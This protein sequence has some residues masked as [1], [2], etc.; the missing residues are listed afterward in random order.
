MTQQPAPAA[1][2]PVVP[3]PG[4]RLA[5]T[6]RGT[7]PA[8]LL[9]HGITCSRAHDARY[10]LP[11]YAPVAAHH[12]LVAYDARGHGESG[13]R[14]EPAAY[15]WSALAG[16]ML[17]LAD[18]FS[19]ETPVAAI[20]CSMGTATALHAALRAPERF[21]ALVLTAVP[22]AWETRAAQAGL[23]RR[24][25]ALAAEDPTALDALRAAA[26]TPPIFAGRD[27]GGVDVRAALLPAVLEGAAGSDLPA[28]ETLAR[29]TVP[30]LVLAWDTDPGHPVSSAE[31]VARHIPGARLS[32]A[33]TAAEVEGWGQV[34]ADFLREAGS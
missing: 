18:H 28:P 9:A 23:Y 1:D 14:P 5:C 24:M 4:A 20:G 31:T 34:A 8:V 16:D 30:T 21:F 12:R 15:E 2:F 33:R 6:V 13:G 3:L 22:T 7:G 10:G 32:V 17:A 19:P 26:P 29:I 11:D 27:Q 25:A